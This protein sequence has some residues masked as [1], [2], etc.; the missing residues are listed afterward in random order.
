MKKAIFIIIVAGLSQAI[1][2]QLPQIA[3]I[4]SDKNTG[5]SIQGA[6]V[7]DIQG[8]NYTYSNRNGY[9]SLG[10][11]GGK[12]TL[13]VSASGYYRKIFQLD[14][15]G[16]KE[17]DVILTPIDP[18]NPDTVSNLSSGI[19]DYRS[20]HIAP[21]MAQVKTMP[22]LLSE[23]DPV[24]L[25]QNI[26][27]VNGGIEGLSGMY[28]R[29]GN[30]DQNLSL[31]DGLPL[32]GNGHIFGFLSGYNP[33][34]LRDIQFY[35][36]V[37]PARYGGRAGAVL[38]VT[39]KEGNKT[40]WKGNYSANFLTMKLSMDGPISDKV[41]ASLGIRRSYLDLFLPRSGGDYVFYNI[42]DLNLKVAANLNKNNKLT[43]FVYNGRDKYAIKATS[44]RRDS[45]N[46]LISFNFQNA[47]YWQNTL[48][49]ANLSH[50]FNSRHYAL[51]TLGMSR[52]A[53]KYNF[54]LNGSVTTDT[55]SNTAKIELGRVNAITDIVGKADFEYNLLNGSYL[56]YGAEIIHH[57]FKPSVAHEQIVSSGSGETDS[58]YGNSN[59]QGALEASVYGE[60]ETVLS[61]GL[62]LNIGA[63]LWTFVGKDKTFFF[64]EPRIF[65]S[66]QL[67]GQKALKF[68][69]S[70]ANQ[71]VN[72]LA[73]VN[74][75][76]PSN[77]W[78]P[79]AK[80]FS[81]QQNLQFTAGYYRPIKYGIEFSL[82]AYY[83]I[84]K[85]VTDVT[86]RDEG[87]LLKNY[88]QP[89]LAQGKGTAYGLEATFMKKH[90]RLNGVAGYTWSY[91]NR[92]IPDINFGKTFPF[93]WDRRHKFSIMGVYHISDVFMLNFG[94]VIMTG[95]AVS[96]PTGKYV[97]ADGTF[98]FDYAEKNNFRMPTYRR[99]DI[100]FTK[101]INPYRN[102][103]K[104]FWGINIYNAL[105]FYN[106]LFIQIKRD[107]KDNVNKAYGQSF[108][109]FIPSAFYRWEF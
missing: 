10:L 104:Q 66:Q 107:A 35:K 49:G 106:P 32:Y 41:T 21:L 5:E 83:K 55:G 108:F 65:L 93:R 78:F 52:Y 48:L 30:S 63:R 85:G 101:E 20:G 15:F 62:K 17:M 42:H 74:A 6:I 12:Y 51:F 73:S 45:T 43:F 11:G 27:G 4:V 100:G 92:T 53:Y 94:L 34:V 8:N 58:T 24:K 39:L 54:S 91:S 16:T 77:I 89:M 84:M 33:D 46:R 47:V 98:I 97:A 103:N 87:D 79:S 26:P 82:D 29:G 102:L 23:P 19:N 56:R 40:E 60:Y 96:V 76:L 25:L 50:K 88:W 109:P 59:I 64:P 80:N 38:D 61:A 3:G 1:F 75:S 31:M 99:F 57:G 9:Y 72:Q 90:G 105:G 67:Q 7:G 70:I 13:F 44:T 69:F 37:T 68:G 86:G 95:N 2:A 14:V 22:T 28:V 81:T 36:G 71:G 18:L